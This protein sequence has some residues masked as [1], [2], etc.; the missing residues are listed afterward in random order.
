[1]RVR[2]RQRATAQSPVVSLGDADEALAEFIIVGAHQGIGADH[3]RQADM[4]FQQH[5]IADGVG[6]VNAAGGI[7]QN[8][9]ADAEL[10]H[11]ANRECD[12]R[13]AVAFVE[14]SAPLLRGHRLPFQFADDQIALMAVYSRDRPT[15]DIR[16][17]DY[18][19]VLELVSQATQA[20]TKDQANCRLQLRALADGVRRGA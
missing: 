17:G 16:V 3:A 13:Q 18:R 4:V 10:F 1:M 9:R 15:G 2:Y 19:S 6:R 8:H 20:R 5:Q 11:D 7:R 12:L 14:V